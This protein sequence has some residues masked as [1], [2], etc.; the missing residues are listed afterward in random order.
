VSRLIAADT[1]GALAAAAEALRRG[2][3]V[4]IPT[5]TVYGLAVLPEQGPAERLVAAK[6]RSADKGIQLLVDSIEQAR[7]VA[8]LTPLA[9][10][11]ATA[12]WPGGLTIVLRCRPDAKVPDLLGGGRRTIGVRLPDHPIPRALSRLLG[13]LAASS[14][15]LSGQ[16][17]ATD[18]QSV[19]NALGALVAVVI[20][21]GPV[22][23]GIPSTV[24]DCSDPAVGAR[25]LREGAIPASTIARLAGE[26]YTGP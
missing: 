26:G 14:A 1:P 8:I 10:R 24:V 6:Q 22:V 20:D 25:I 7:R 15:N 5:E 12:L 13:P 2:E 18:A 23:G 21:D 17:P 19:I 16:P 11:L 3:I 9:E 4:A